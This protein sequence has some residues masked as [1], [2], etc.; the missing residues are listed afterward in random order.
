MA[1][2]KMTLEQLLE[3]LDLD[4]VPDN[5]ALDSTLQPTLAPRFRAGKSTAPP[6]SPG[7]TLPP[8]S[9][10]DRT[11]HEMRIRGQ[12]AEG[13]MGSIFLAEQPALR[14]DVALKTLKDEFMTPVFASRLRREA[15]VLALVEHPNVVPVHALDTD[16]RNAPVVVMKRI[17][18][19]P[20]RTLIREP[21]HPALPPAT[22]R[23]AWHLRVLMRICEA[24]HYAHSRGVL[25]LDLKPDNVMIGAFREVYLVDWGVAVSTDDAQRGWLPM[26]D[27]VSEILGTPAYLAP[28]M[29][30]L[31]RAPLSPSTDVYLLGG[32][33]HEILLGRPPHEGE[34]LHDLLYAAYDAKAPV[35]PPEVPEELGRI[36]RKAMAPEASERFGSAEALRTALSDFLEHRVAASVADGAREALVELRMLVD[37]SAREPTQPKLRI[38]KRQDARNA[39]VQRAFARAR[40]GFAEALRHHAQAED[41]Q[42]GLASALLAMTGYHLRRMETA[43]AEGLLEEL[44]DDPR[45]ERLRE[46]AAAQRAEAARMEKLAEIDSVDVGSRSR[47]ILVFLVAM[48]VSIPGLVGYVGT[49]LGLYHYEWWH[50]LAYTAF[51]S[52]VLLGGAFVLRRSLMSTRR[53]RAIMWSITLLVLL[54]VA[55]RAVSYSLGVREEASLALELFFF[56]SGSTVAAVLADRR[57]YFAAVAFFAGTALVLLA[58]A[59]MLLWVALTAFAGPGAL[60]WAWMRAER[61]PPDSEE[62]A[63]GRP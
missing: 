5:H 15:R 55:L 29:V 63:R 17:E 50:T 36:L 31:S 28:E 56:G 23:L 43:S 42:E 14:R 24:V 32:T 58:P 54:S 2:G 49:R 26:A 19:T 25:H 13:G 52:V 57:F 12:L 41:A 61:A 35:V 39:R 38:A 8:P 33:L 48:T 4:S 11:S 16:E 46:E 10:A 20:W 6:K 34:S 40:F 47:G 60:A 53:S 59:H 37:E 22:D 7:P 51:L 1:T 30:D 18:G 45:A 9:A 27:E 21:D 62:S 3:T 44:G